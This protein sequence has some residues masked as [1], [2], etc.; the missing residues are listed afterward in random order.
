MPIDEHDPTAGGPDDLRPSKDRPQQPKFSRIGPYRLLQPI[1]RGG[2]GEVWEAE[3]TEPVQ[4]RVAIKLLRPGLDSQE[5]LARFEIER[6]ALALMDHTCIAK[7]YD[8]GTAPDGR[9]YFVMELINGVPITT[10]CDRERLTT[11]ERLELFMKVCDGIQH[12]HQKAII[13][14]DIKPSNVLVV[15]QGNEPVPRIIDFGVAKAVAQ[16]LA[17][18]T[19]FTELGQLIGTPEYMSP[20]QAEMGGRDI[21]TRSDVYSLGV[22][23]YEL[24]TSSLPFSPEELRAAGHD[25]IRR[26]IRED[27]PPRPSTRVSSLG[28]KA[29]DVASSHNTE[30]GQLMRRLRG[31]LDWITMKALEKD[32]ARR[33]VSPS[34]LAADVH[35]HLLDQPVLAGPPS[36][37][38]RAQK[39]IRRHRVSVAFA[40]VVASLLVALVVSIGVQARRVATE[41]D[42]ANAE[43]ATAREVTEFLV[44]L[45]EEV[46][47]GNARGNQVTARE[48][49]DQ[50]V[51]RIEDRL[52][53]EPRTRATL[54]ETMGRVYTA[55]GLYDDA[56]PMLERGVEIREQS[57]EIDPLALA[58]ALHELARLMHWQGAYEDGIEVARR[59]VELREQH[60]G[61]N[62]PDVATALNGLGNF[63]EKVGQIDAAKQTHQRAIEIRERALG[64]DHSDL[65][66]SLHNLAILYLEDGTYDRAEELLKRSARIEEIV[67]GP[68]SYELATSLHVLA[69][70]Y[71]SMERYEDAI[72]YEERALAMRE[73]VL[74]E[75]HPHVS[76]SLT[77]LGNIYRAIDQPAV[78]EPHLRRALAIAR[79]A[80][81]VAYPEWRWITRSLASCLSEQG[82]HGEAEDL[83]LELVTATESAELEGALT[84][85]LNQL[86]E[87]YR[88]MGRRDDAERVL[89]RSLAIEERVSGEDHPYVAEALLPLAEIAQEAGR[90]DEARER[91]ERALAI[92]AA[93]QAAGMSEY[94]AV[95]ERCAEIVGLP[96]EE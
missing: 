43:A 11:R 20:E 96:P 84:P 40:G 33:Y 44:G 63:Q 16:P 67:R 71:E 75:N 61:P 15:L 24:L 13:H 26:R 58:T 60:L 19:L 81:T 64:P 86:G 88:E 83:L 76:F 31:D 12:A 18:R 53:D 28:D 4:R 30:T 95:E 34:E 9:P 36:M 68:V 17:E 22:M 69:I 27:E 66:Q 46:D 5:I 57:G 52:E 78:A 29:T 91:C 54:L 21:D 82:R 72:A 80:W 3:Q 74:G 1:G 7:V 59:A 37:S 93:Q 55:L 47:P 6:Q 90:R 32:R 49:L 8:A 51:Q 70:L 25:E 62:H 10:Y 79:D 94:R 56:L 38:Y 92:A 48:V 50:G 41:R 77:T 39:F 89:L 87:L 23:L 45:F 14:R 85:T 65:G 42:R 2:M 35:R 73:E